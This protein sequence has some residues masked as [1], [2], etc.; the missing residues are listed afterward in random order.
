IEGLIVKGLEKGDHVTTEEALAIL[1]M[2]LENDTG[3]KI[4]SYFHC[5]E[6]GEVERLGLASDILEHIPFDGNGMANEHTGSLPKG[7]WDWLVSI[8]VGFLELVLF[9]FT[10]PF[11]LFGLLISA[12]I[13]IGITLIG[14][15]FAAIVLLL[16]KIIIIIIIFIMFA[17]AL[18]TTLICFALMAIIIGTI[19][20]ITAQHVE[21]GLFYVDFNLWGVSGRLES[22]IGWTPNEFL[23]IDIPVLTTELSLAGETFLSTSEGMGSG[24]YNVQTNTLIPTSIEGSGGIGTA[25]DIITL[26]DASVS[27]S[28]GWGDE[29]FTF[30]VC[31]YNSDNLAPISPYPQ[32]VIEEE[33]WQMDEVDDSDT[34]YSDGKDYTL[35]LEASGIFSRVTQVGLLNYRFEVSDGANFAQ[36]PLSGNYDDLYLHPIVLTA[37][38]VDREEGT[39]DDSFTFEVTYDHKSDAPADWVQ[40]VIDN[41]HWNM[42][43]DP[44]DVN[45][46]DGQDYILQIT[47]QEIFNHINKRGVINYHFEASDGAFAAARY[48]ERSVDDTSFYLSEISQ[49]IIFDRFTAGLMTVAAVWTIAL[50][51]YLTNHLSGSNPF[52]SWAPPLGFGLL[53]GI[54]LAAGLVSTFGDKSDAGFAYPLGLGVG[55]LILYGITQIV[56]SGKVFDARRNILFVK[57]M[58]Q[59]MVDVFLLLSSQVFGIA[60]KEYYCLY[61]NIFCHYLYCR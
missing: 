31:Y 61:Y 13:Y 36:S 37:G 1:D 15:I 10:L 4:Y 55:C 2:V 58:A 23:G 30:D 39:L 42:A 49:Q 28:S 16:I 53:L 32:L 11:L 50:G 41:T 18:L 20:L 8:F 56:Q 47:G 12:L 27:P 22:Q 52:M 34:T 21:L 59:V 19:A 5:D 3:H 51:F 7:F 29:T 26:L 44:I 33:I 40:L 48:P 24:D 17:L 45:P 54:I 57:N 38:N 35:T 60:D 9:I 46:T 25:E 43:L 6:V 14:P